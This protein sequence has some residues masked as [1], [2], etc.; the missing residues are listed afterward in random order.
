MGYAHSTIDRRFPVAHPERRRGNGAGDLRSH[1]S[2]F[3]VA[4]G[5]RRTGPARPARPQ[6]LGHR[7]TLAL[8]QPPAAPLHQRVVRTIQ[9]LLAATLLITDPAVP[10]VA[11]LVRSADVPDAAMTQLHQMSDCQLRDRDVVDVV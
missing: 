7:R 8:V 6:R 5:R 2:Y 4:A 1:V 9:S 10:A 11:D 3:A